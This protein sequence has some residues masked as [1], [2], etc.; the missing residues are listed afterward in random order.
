MIER[1]SIAPWTHR[2]ELDTAFIGIT[3][4]TRAGRHYIA[5]CPTFERAM[6]M[7]EHVKTLR[8]ETEEEARGV[9]DDL[10]TQLG[11]SADHDDIMNEPVTI[12][13][14]SLVLPIAHVD[15]FEKSIT[16]GAR[17]IADDEFAPELMTGVTGKFSGFYF[18]LHQDDQPGIT[19][20]LVY[21]VLI[22]RAI[23]AN[24][25]TLQFASGDVN[26]LTTLDF[27]QDRHNRELFDAVKVFESAGEEV[28]LYVNHLLSLLMS[29]SGEY[30]ADDLNDIADIIQMLSVHE[31]L[32]DVRQQSIESLEAVITLCMPPRLAKKTHSVEHTAGLYRI[33]TPEHTTIP[34]PYQ[35]DDDDQPV[36]FEAASIKEVI[37]MPAYDIDPPESE[38]EMRYEP[39]IIVRMGDDVSCCVPLSKVTALT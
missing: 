5:D 9:L 18:N 34:V 3:G 32:K 33:E 23:I 14:P 30:T 26:H 20:T 28:V 4:D 22:G 39:Y 10:V 8:W 27:L 17:R 21:Q 38:A 29:E 1:D 25:C 6:T 35:L 11:K 7:Q 15:S 13:G 24:A 12:G 31:D 36:V 2:K 16:S 37:V 19:A